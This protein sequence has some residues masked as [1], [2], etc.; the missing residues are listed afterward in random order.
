M[1]L[2]PL[3]LAGLIALSPVDS[4][5]G[6]GLPLDPFGRGKPHSSLEGTWKLS[7][8]DG[9]ARPQRNNWRGV[10]DLVFKDGKVLAQ[11]GCN[12][13]FG[14]YQVIEGRLQT[15]LGMTTVACFRVGENEWDYAVEKALESQVFV[16]SDRGR[17]LTLRD[18]AGRKYVFQ[19]QK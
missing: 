18:Q 2:Q 9:A 19:R 5:E 11:D 15:A 6:G 14:S 3:I 17:R 7:S 16:V 10:F 13:V 4:Q 8:V 12:R 1:F